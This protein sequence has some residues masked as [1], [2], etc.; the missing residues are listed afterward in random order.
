MSPTSLQ[1]G[2]VCSGGEQP[3]AS[4]QELHWVRQSLSGC[5]HA[6]VEWLWEVS[7]L[8]KQLTVAYLLLLELLPAAGPT[9][10]GP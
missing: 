5:P 8:E 9:E 1:R 2:G 3:T 6:V 4:P 10:R 7:A